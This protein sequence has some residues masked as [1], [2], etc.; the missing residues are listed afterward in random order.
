MSVNIEELQENLDKGNLLGEEAEAAQKVIDEATAAKE[1]E[2][3]EKKAEED[4][5]AA[6]KMTD[7]E[8]AEAE[9]KAEEEAKAKEE[10]EAKAAYDK[11]SDDEKAE[12]DKKVEEE[13]AAAEEAE[14]AERNKGIK[15]PKFRLDAANVRAK[16]AEI[17]RDEA[18]AKLQEASV[19]KPAE[20]E[21]TAEQIQDKAL[22]E[23]DTKIAEAMK[24]GD[25]GEISKLMAESRAL[26]RGYQNDI[27]MTNLQASS[28]H[29]RAQ[30]DETTLV[31]SIL[32][33]LEEQYPMF[34]ENSDQ[35]NAEANADVIRLQEAFIAS[36]S[37]AADALVEAVNT[38]L[39]KYG[40]T[41]EES[42]EDDGKAEAEKKAAT[43]KAA[44]EKKKQ[45]EKNL[46]AAGKMPP[47]MENA[48]D[49][50]DSAGPTG[51]LP[52][53]LDLTDA[54]YDALPEATRKKMRGDEF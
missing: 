52:N 22:T 11:L 37:T 6:E 36:G 19:A 30:V 54:E 40:F 12:A 1:A 42:P 49:D 39:P 7:D 41:A 14:R 27:N 9:K 35:F 29:T 28:E 15:V 47:D 4:K 3:A 10:E 31:N 46:A 5:L 50:S 25:S 38:T 26:E 8:K 23:I 34:D 44:A 17:E 21:L 32:D 13:K 18:V 2:D 33:Q 20:G 43:E 51:D 48:G 16:K 53:P 24:N 45:V